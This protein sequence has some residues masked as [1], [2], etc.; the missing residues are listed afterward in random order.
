MLCSA[1]ECDTLLGERTVYITARVVH[2][3]CIMDE[4]IQ[5]ATSRMSDLLGCSLQISR[6]LPL[7]PH[8]CF[9]SL[10]FRDW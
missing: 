10:T 8:A 6:R 1:R 3:R 9:S 4:D 5:G 2:L 7:V